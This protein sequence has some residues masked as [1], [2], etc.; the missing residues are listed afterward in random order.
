MFT[1]CQLTFY[2]KCEYFKVETKT[3]QNSY[4]STTEMRINQNGK[5]LMSTKLSWF[6]DFMLFACDPDWCRLSWSNS[7]WE[8]SSYCVR[9]LKI[10]TN[11]H[12]IIFNLIILFVVYLGSVY[13]VVVIGINRTRWHVHGRSIIRNLY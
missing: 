11:I 4:F 6:R 5:K 3:I 13:I 7:H 12:A 8:Q 10:K 9:S 2:F 1:I